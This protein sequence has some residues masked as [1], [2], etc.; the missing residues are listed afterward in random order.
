MNEYDQPEY[1][2]QDNYVLQWVIEDVIR[3]IIRV[4]RSRKCICNKENY[5]IMRND[6]FI[7]FQPYL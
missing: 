7:N 5:N 6:Q 4:K 2:W 1:R 3:H